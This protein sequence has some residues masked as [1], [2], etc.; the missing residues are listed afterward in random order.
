[1]K[2]I[3]CSTADTLLIFSKAPNGEELGLES[4]IAIKYDNVI[5]IASKFWSLYYYGNK[6][7]NIVRMKK[8]VSRSKNLNNTDKLNKLN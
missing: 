1:M 8:N 6:R 4:G 2:K 5:N 7:S 3:E